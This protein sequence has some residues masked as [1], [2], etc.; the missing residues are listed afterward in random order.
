MLGIGNSKKLTGE[1]KL[2][3]DFDFEGVVMFG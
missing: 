2:E 1:V 3:L